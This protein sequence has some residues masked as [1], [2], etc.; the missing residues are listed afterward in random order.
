ME[1]ICTQ[2]NADKCGMGMWFALW[3]YITNKWWHKLA[4]GDGAVE[5]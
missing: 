5:T 1:M 2:M 3:G 4:N